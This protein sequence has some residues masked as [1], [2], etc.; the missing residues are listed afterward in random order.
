MDLLADPLYTAENAHLTADCAIR[1][2]AG[3][4]PVC[5]RGCPILVIGWGRIGKCLAAML[6]Q[7]GADVTVSARKAEDLALLSALGYGTENTATLG[8]GLLR[9]RVIFNTVPA[10]VISPVQA[11]HCEKDCLLIDLASSQGICCPE[12]IWARGLPGKMVPESS[13]KLIGRTVI[14]Q[15]YGKESI[16]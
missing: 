15:L 6:K 10:E 1:V 5:F 8:P 2:A 13:G 12:A 14:R 4:L 3:K 9:Y 16:K 7:L 11:G